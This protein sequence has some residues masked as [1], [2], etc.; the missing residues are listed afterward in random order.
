MVVSPLWDIQRPEGE[1][2]PA[3][4]HGDLCFWDLTSPPVKVGCKQPPGLGA[5]V[6]GAP[7]G[8]Q[9]AGWPPRTPAEMFPSDVYC[10]LNQTLQDGDVGRIQPADVFCLAWSEFKLKKIINYQH[11]K[12]EDWE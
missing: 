12:S 11:L 10:F 1:T 4:E 2:G 7:E 8:K 9:R 5:E 6:L 3:V